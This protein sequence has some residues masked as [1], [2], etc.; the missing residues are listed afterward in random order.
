[1]RI[2]DVLIELYDRFPPIVHEVADGLDADDL[3][4]RPSA[5]ANS[6]GW[7]LWHPIRVQDDHISELLDEPQVWVTGDWASRFQLEPDPSNTGYGHA[8]ADVDAVRPD[9]PAALTAYCDA[10]ADRTRTFLGSVEEADLDRVVDERWDPPVTMGVRLVSV[11]DDDLQHAGQAA[12]ARG[13]L[14]QR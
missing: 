9:G 3:H 1:M 10:V 2:P 14:V 4:W 11:A 5:E 13:L 12:Y 6:I 8:A 7:L